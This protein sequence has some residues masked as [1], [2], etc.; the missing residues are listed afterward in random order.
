MKLKKNL[1][2]AIVKWTLVIILV[3]VQ[4]YPFVYVIFSSLF[5][6]VEASLLKPFCACIRG[7][8][9]TMPCTVT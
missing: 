6:T 9:E 5:L 3:V 2:G 8:R 1:C 4:V 7:G